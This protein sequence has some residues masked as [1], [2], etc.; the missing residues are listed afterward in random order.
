[1]MKFRGIEVEGIWEE[2]PK[3]HCPSCIPSPSKKFPKMPCREIAISLQ[4]QGVHVKLDV[5][6]LIFNTVR[7]KGMIKKMNSLIL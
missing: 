4:L 3:R 6:R 1:M 5:D 7:S 2:T